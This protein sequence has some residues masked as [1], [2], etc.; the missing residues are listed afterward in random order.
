MLLNPRFVHQHILYQLPSA[1]KA[2]SKSSALLWS[3]GIYICSVYV[4]THGT[5]KQPCIFQLSFLYY[6]C[7]SLV[8]SIP[9]FLSGLHHFGSQYDFFFFFSPHTTDHVFK[10]FYALLLWCSHSCPFVWYSETMEIL[11]LECWHSL[12]VWFYSLCVLRFFFLGIPHSLFLHDS[13]LKCTCFLEV[14]R[15][16]FW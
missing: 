5:Y 11:R 3:D 4:I 7:S 13:S 12:L 15:S 9:D 1:M 14:P 8:Y 16:I 6:S 10:T 2:F